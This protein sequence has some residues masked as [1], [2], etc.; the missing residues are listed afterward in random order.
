MKIW[1]KYLCFFLISLTLIGFVLFLY[2]GIKNEK[3]ITVFGEKIESLKPSQEDTGNILDFNLL[4]L[5]KAGEA[6]YGGELTDSL[7]LMHVD[8][9]NKKVTL[10]NIP[11]DLWV[12]VNNKN[13]SS[14]INALYLI[15]NSNPK[16]AKTFELIKTKVTEITG[17]D[18]DNVIV[19]DL[20]GFQEIVDAIGGINIYLEND[21]VDPQMRDPDNRNQIFVIKAGWRYLDGKTT[22]WFIRSRYAPDG[23]FTRIK[24]QQLIFSAI[25]N[26]IG[27]LLNLWD[28]PKIFKLY[29]ALQKH[30]VT[31]LSFDDLIKL[32]KF[33]QNLK[34]EN[35]QYLV[36]SN[37]APDN[38]LISSSFPSTG[39]DGNY[40]NAYTLIPQLGFEKY[41]DIQKYISGKLP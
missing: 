31:D 19:F 1:L 14:K 22:G 25:K 8:G 6:S 18:V 24:H 27:G 35:T 26:K 38:L 20:Q 39:P 40:V 36:L 17:L 29:Q 12:N 34:E 23:D 28:V 3:Q 37:R 41:A 5:G 10:I 16:K 30:M 9:Y 32:A 13:Y 15:E 33:S 11:R 2:W 7:S 21:F 4:I